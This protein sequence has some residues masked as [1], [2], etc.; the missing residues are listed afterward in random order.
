MRAL[1]DTNCFLWGITDSEKLSLAARSFMADLDNSLCLSAAS[2]WEIAVKVS[3]GKLELLRPFDQLIPEQLAVNAIDILPIEPPH[4]SRLIT[5]PFYHRDPFDRLIIA[6]AQTEDIALLSSD[7][8]FQKYDV[9]LI[10]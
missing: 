1:L 10:W 9:K 2:L 5:L 8:A 4:L 6:Q 7:T 3:I